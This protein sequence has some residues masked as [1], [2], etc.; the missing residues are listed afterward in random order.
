VKPNG[1]GQS[2]KSLEHNN[3]HVMGYSAESD[4]HNQ[5]NLLKQS[6]N[7]STTEQILTNRNNTT[8]MLSEN[9]TGKDVETAVAIYAIKR[10][11]QCATPSN[12]MRTP[13]A[14]LD[15]YPTNK[16]DPTIGPTREG[17]R[18]RNPVVKTELTLVMT[19]S[20]SKSN[21]S[22]HSKLTKEKEQYDTKQADKDKETAPWGQARRKRPGSTSSAGRP[23]FALNKT[24]FGHQNLQSL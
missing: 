14:T 11:K 13:K 16:L 4:Q 15:N 8:D 6:G 7:K 10:A 20:T 17:N 3:L 1:A 21:G 19:S 12:E 5:R 22:E 2:F 23:L 24:H 9:N 18:D